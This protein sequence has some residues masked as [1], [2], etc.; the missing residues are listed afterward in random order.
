MKRSLQLIILLV[1]TFS[2]KI[3][4]YELDIKKIEEFSQLLI[5]ETEK[6]PKNIFKYLSSG[7]VV[8]M[9]MGNEA[10]SFTFTYNKEEYIESITKSLMELGNSPEVGETDILDVKLMP[11]NQGQ[12]T[13]RQFSKSMRRYVWS[14]FNIRIEE[15]EIKIVKISDS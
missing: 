5:K 1:I 14:I 8:E 9:T 13:V 11:N 10:N 7:V 15:N 3:S 6:S 4:A 2:V 12:F